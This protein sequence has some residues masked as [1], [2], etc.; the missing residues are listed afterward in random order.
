MAKHIKVLAKYLALSMIICT[1]V[2]I[3]GSAGIEDWRLFIAA[4]W[5]V[6]GLV[7]LTIMARHWS[8]QL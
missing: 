7:P 1:P 8:T 3:V 5:F 2:V 6:I 4:M